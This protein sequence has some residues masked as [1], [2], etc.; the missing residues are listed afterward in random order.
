MFPN[1]L[2]REYSIALGPSSSCQLHPLRMSVTH[3]SLRRL[4]LPHTRSH[5]ATTLAYESITTQA[6]L[7]APMLPMAGPIMHRHVLI[8][9]LRFDLPTLA[10][11]I[12][13]FSPCISTYSNGALNSPSIVAS[14]VAGVGA[15]TVVPPLPTPPAVYS[16][17]C[18]R[19]AIEKHRSPSMY[20][21][22]AHAS[23][24][25]R[26]SNSSPN[27]F[28]QHHCECRCDCSLFDGRQMYGDEVIADCTL[29]DLM[30]GCPYHPP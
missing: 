25:Q 14:A 29:H 4:S 22:Q 18:P 1:G 26:N 9:F 8:V 27:H 17:V 15:E 10:D 30:Q 23:S 5:S 16:I 19:R 20:G 6:P 3:L 2:L 12:L 24:M 28:R 21:A 13:R 7:V 11:T